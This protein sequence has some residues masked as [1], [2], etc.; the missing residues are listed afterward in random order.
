MK[1]FP[2]AKLCKPILAEKIFSSPSESN[3]AACHE[4]GYITLFIAFEELFGNS[5]SMLFKFSQ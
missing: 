1:D 2:G 3:K 5:I 4:A